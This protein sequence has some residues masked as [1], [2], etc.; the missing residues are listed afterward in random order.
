MTAHPSPDPAHG[1]FETL[2]VFEQRPVE[3][4]AHLDRL[5]H[6]L[7][8]L[9]DAELPPGLAAD[10]ERRARKLRLGR[11]R[12]AVKVIGG[13]EA[14]LATEPVD[15]ADFFPRWERG[16]DSSPLFRDGGLGRHKWADRRALQDVP[17]GSVPLLLDRGHEVLE[18]GRA[19]VF[20]VRDGALMTP[21][22]DGR[23]LPGI[24]RAGAIAAAHEA[25]I[26]VVE[27]PLTGADLLAADE[28]FLTGSVRGVEPAR[29]LDGAA[30]PAATELSREVA[31][32]LR[33]RWQAPPLPAAA[34]T[35]AASPPLGPP[36]R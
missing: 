6:S 35:P 24:A 16:A 2:L 23:I 15:P 5:A 8:T 13:A 9:F 36:A 10:A 29:S 12:I 28:V 17:E 21:P 3:L 31:D 7:R 11:L 32:G 27:G 25:G 20:A 18:A 34:A 14:T 22:D 4:E 30:L 19:N 26:E 1:L 33:R